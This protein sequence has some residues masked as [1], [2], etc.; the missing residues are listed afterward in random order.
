MR[1]L[2][3]LIDKQLGKFIGD[4]KQYLGEDWQLYVLTANQEEI[5][6][7]IIDFFHQQKSH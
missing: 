7:R 1:Q 2:T 5:N 4:F 3:G 6:A